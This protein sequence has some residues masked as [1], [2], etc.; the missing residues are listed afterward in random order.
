MAK[1][2]KN[3]AFQKRLKWP[4]QKHRPPKTAI[5]AENTKNN[6]LPKTPKMAE[7]EIKKPFENSQ[8]G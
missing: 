1:K 2:N 3:T 4:K 8:N 5:M 7:N 6:H